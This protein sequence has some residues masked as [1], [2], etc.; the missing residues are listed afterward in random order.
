MEQ[1]EMSECIQ[2]FK[3]RPVFK[4]LFLQMKRKYE[5][6]GHLGGR[7]VLSGLSAEEKM[8]LGGFFKKDFLGK[9]KVVISYQEME[10][11]LLDSRFQKLCWQDILS[12]YFGQELISKKENAERKEKEQEL[13][14]RKLDQKYREFYVDERCQAWVHSL[15]EEGELRHQKEKEKIAYEMEKTLLAGTML[16]VKRGGTESLPVFSAKVTGDPHYFDDGTLGEKLL[17][18]Y[19]EYFLGKESAGELSKTEQKGKLFYRAGIMKDDLSNVVLAYRIHGRN[20]R[21]GNLHEGL[22]GFAKENDPVQITLMTLGN[23][24]EAWADSKQVFAENIRK[25][26]SFAGTGSSVW[27]YGCCWIFYAETILFTMQ[28][29]LIRKGF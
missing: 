20:L 10:K 16:P 4:K 21:N 1:H 23:L 2:Y 6:L 12:C 13:F 24:K 3:E 9:Q 8:Q 25:R 5:G 27:L 17:L 22:E 19:L 14:L 29:I 26:L 7:A 18:S 11:A 28:V 15:W